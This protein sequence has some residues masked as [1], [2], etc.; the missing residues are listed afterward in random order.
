MLNEVLRLSAL[1][2]AAA[3]A[4]DELLTVAEASKWQATATYDDVIGLLDRIRLRSAPGT[5]ASAS[6]GGPTRAGRSRW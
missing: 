6:W 5:C 1:L 3:G 2:V 4:D